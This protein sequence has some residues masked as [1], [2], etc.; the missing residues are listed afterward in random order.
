MELDCDGVLHQ[1]DSPQFDEEW[2]RVESA[3]K[4]TRRDDRLS[5]E[6]WR[7][8][9][10]LRRLRRRGMKSVG[11]KE[12]IAMLQRFQTRKQYAALKKSCEA[13]V[14]EWRWA[15]SL[16]LPE[17]PYDDVVRGMKP[18]R[19]VKKQPR[20]GSLHG[21][22]GDGRIRCIRGGDRARPDRDVYEQFLIHEDNGFWCI[23]FDASPNKALLAVKWYETEGERWLRS[24]QVSHSGLRECILRWEADRLVRVVDRSWPGAST[25]NPRA[26][27]KLKEADAEQTT[28]VYSYAADGELDRVTEQ[29]DLGDFPP[30]V[31]VEYQRVPKGV[32]LDVLLRQ[33]EDLLVAEIPRAIRAAKAREVVYGLLVQF[34]GVDTDLGGFAPPLFLPTEALRRRLLAGHPKDA[35]WYPWAVPEWENDPGAVRVTCHN[36]T[37]DEKLHLI[38]QLTVVQAR[39]Y[40][41]VR[42]MFQRVCARLNARS[43]KGILKTTDDFIVIPFDPHGELDARVDLKASVPVEKLR[44]LMD[45]GYVRRMKLK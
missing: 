33:A 17:L 29:T 10:D 38:F 13:S 26:A 36:P 25:S 22:S 3:V 18:P 30:W 44:L 42:K 14:T 8:I 28:H 35:D 24:L 45:R 23:Y 12:L 9:G 11:P 2:P 34:T 15:T 21:V 41:P 6:V 20:H 5:E 4:S 32:D 16:M 27:A 7:L 31:R 40:G 37:L 43:W 1:R 19:W 39:G